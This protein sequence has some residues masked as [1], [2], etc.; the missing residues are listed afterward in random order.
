VVILVLLLGYATHTVYKL[1]IRQVWKKK[2]LQRQD[3]PTEHM[4]FLAVLFFSRMFPAFL[5]SM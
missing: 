1:R 2:Y 3:F 5:Q 4:K